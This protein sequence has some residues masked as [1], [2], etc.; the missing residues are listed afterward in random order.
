M[1]SNDELSNDT[2][3]SCDVESLQLA[4]EG[5]GSFN[6]I[7]QRYRVGSWKRRRGGGRRGRRK[8]YTLCDLRISI[9][10]QGTSLKLVN[11]KSPMPSMKENGESAARFGK[12]FNLTIY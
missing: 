6:S 2:S 11:Y 1:S 3:S 7:V 5:E 4:V 12:I 10:K 9:R 8:W